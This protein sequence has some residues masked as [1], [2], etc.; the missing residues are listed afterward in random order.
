ML[1]NVVELRGF[2]EAGNVFIPLTPTLSLKGR[3]SKSITA[4]G[5]VGAGDLGDVLVGQFTIRS[6]STM[7]LRISPSPDW[8][9]D[10]E[11][12]AS[13]KPARPVGARW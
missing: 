1:A 6:A 4:P 8:L 3:G 11:P 9:D 7:A 12:L 13:T 2:A 5:V 10:I